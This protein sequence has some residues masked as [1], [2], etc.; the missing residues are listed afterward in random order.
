[1]GLGQD[2]LSDPDPIKEK[3]MRKKVTSK[4]VGKSA[5][6]APALP[7]QKT[8]M[9]TKLSDYI[10]MFFG[11]PGVGKTTFVNDFGNVL[12]LSTDRGTRFMSAMRVEC[13]TW[14]KFKDVIG[15]L[16]KPGAPKYDYICIDHVDDWSRLC[17]DAV[18]EKLG[19]EALGDLDWGKGWKAY[20][21]ELYRFLAELK[22]LGIGIVFVAHEVTKT[23]NKN[24]IDVDVCQ[25]DM[26]KRAWKAIIP[27][28]DLVGYCGFKVLN[29]KG[30]R[31]E[32]RIL[33]TDP[34]R[35]LFAKDRTTRQRPSGDRSWEVLDGQKFLKTFGA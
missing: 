9:A 3:K 15:Q 32:V 10:V 20:K 33:E 13:L 19:I 11:Q 25:P 26:D 7:S 29:V 5:S 14:Q 31:S 35:D 27:L 16:K 12:F 30:K 24:G 8:S 23:V 22:A 6:T 18:C 1:M 34:R 2:Y 17:E 21:D 4:P 28:C